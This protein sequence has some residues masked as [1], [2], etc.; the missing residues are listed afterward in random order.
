[1]QNTSFQTLSIFSHYL[2][3]PM[4]QYSKGCCHL[5][6]ISSCKDP[7]KCIS[8]HPQGSDLSADDQYSIPGAVPLFPYVCIFNHKHNQIDGS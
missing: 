8:F 7:S 5:A 1:M 2:Q 3:G 4:E 6:W